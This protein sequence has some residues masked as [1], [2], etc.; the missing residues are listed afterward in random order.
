LL[1]LTA[2]FL[3]AGSFGLLTFFWPRYWNSFQRA[4]N[5]LVL[6][7]SGLGLW[8]N[9]IGYHMTSEN[10]VRVCATDINVT[11]VAGDDPIAVWIDRRVNRDNTLWTLM[12][13]QVLLWGISNWSDRFYQI[14]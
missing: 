5:Q 11:W 13:K 3:A 12:E 1:L 7:G 6:P 9:R 14:H 4:L 8:A 2:L 10:L